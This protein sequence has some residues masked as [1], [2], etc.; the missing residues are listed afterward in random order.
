VYVERYTFNTMIAGVMEAMNALNEQTNR[1]VWSEG[2]WILSSI[3]EPIVPHLCWELS[4]TLFSGK[5]LTSQCVLEEVF[6]VDV[7]TLGVSVN[8]KNRSTIEVSMQESEAAIVEIAK[9]SVEKWIEGKEIL[10]SIVV[11]GKLVNLV[12]KG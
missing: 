11:H 12:V 9:A 10:K 2:Y 8:G 6:E 3:M 1:E 4:Q 7:L 5:N